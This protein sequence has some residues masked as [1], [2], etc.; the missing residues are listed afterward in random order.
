MKDIKKTLKV[1]QIVYALKANRRAVNTDNPLTPVRVTKIGSKYFYVTIYIDDNDLSWHAWKNSKISFETL[2]EA[3]DYVSTMSI[4][5]SEEE[6]NLEIE[7]N[8]LIDSI[9]KKLLNSYRPLHEISTDDLKQIAKLI[10]ISPDD[11]KQIV[12]L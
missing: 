1:G 9:T 3:S 11:L 12:K 2:T 8:D 5:F 6:Y 10:G 4:Y 7:K